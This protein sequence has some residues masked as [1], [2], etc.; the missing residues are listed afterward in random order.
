[1]IIHSYLTDGMFENAKLYLD[2]FKYYN[3][4]DTKI[5]LDT[6][7]LNDK[8]QKVLSKKY[9]NLEIRNKPLD[10]KDIAKKSGMNK[11]IIKKYKNEVETYSS[12]STN[13][14]W[15]LY[16][17]VEDRYRSCLPKV[18]QEYKNKEDYLLHT[19]IDLYFRGNMKNLFDFVR[20]HD[21][22]IRFRPKAIENNR[23]WRCVLGNMIGLKLNDNVEKFLTT[24]HK[25][26]DEVPLHKKPKGYGQ[27]SFYY[28][29]LEHTNDFSW[30]D[31]PNSLIP[32]SK[33]PNAYIWSS[34]RGGNKDNLKRFIEEFKK[35]KDIG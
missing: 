21:I 31:I 30:G 10:F 15:K 16:I 29:Y 27:S 26:I 3:G 20:S 6:R 7:N 9:K 12:N 33:E 18:F 8:Q 25:K 28:A 23:Y 22:S 5:I 11:E 13:V 35:I 34:N 17:S 14:I 24:W 2:S 32:K 1:M 4:E 19:D